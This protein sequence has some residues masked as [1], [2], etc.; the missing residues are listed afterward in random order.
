MLASVA[1]LIP[2][3]HTHNNLKSCVLACRG[4]FLT[5]PQID[6]KMSFRVMTNN[7]MVVITRKYL[8]SVT[9]YALTVFILLL[10]GI[11]PA[12]TL[13]IPL[14]REFF[15]AK[16]LTRPSA[17]CCTPFGALLHSLG[18]AVALP[19]AR[20]CTPLGALAFLRGK[21]HLT[22]EHSLFS[23]EEIKRGRE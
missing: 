23:R 16:K 10:A 14:F 19:W 11:I 17:R 1:A 2:P 5:R 22:G 18:R 15:S 7:I 13:K 20:C 3:S 9:M 4:G 12:E 21:F 6:G 8:L